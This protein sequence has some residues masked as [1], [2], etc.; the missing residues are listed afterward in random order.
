MSRNVCNG[1]NGET[2]IVGWKKFKYNYKRCLLQRRKVD[3]N[4]ESDK[5]V[6][7]DEKI[8]QKFAIGLANI[9][10]GCQKWP[11]WTVAILTKK[12]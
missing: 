9:Q 1:E 11:P 3:E 5:N 6:K 12:G 2:A 8:L 4:G 7:F 10:V